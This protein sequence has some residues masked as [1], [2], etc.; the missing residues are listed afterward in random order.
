M[1][2]AEAVSPRERH[3]F[4]VSSNP[5]V[6]CCNTC[7][8]VRDAYMKKGWAMPSPDSVDQCKGLQL[9]EDDLKALQEGCQIYGYLEVNRVSGLT[10]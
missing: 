2:G 4:R 6:R 1:I 10:L 3:Q 8:E 7:M 9:N 5:S